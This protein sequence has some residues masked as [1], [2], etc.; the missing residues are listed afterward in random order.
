MIRQIAKLIRIL[1]SE[2]N[3]IQI[4]LAICFGLIVGFTQFTSVHNLII[5]FIVLFIRVNLSAFILGALTFKSFSLLLTG[6]FHK[7]GLWLL[8]AESFNGL[9][10]FLYNTTFWKFDRFNNTIVA[11]GIVVSVI[12]FLPMLFFFN[13]LITKYRSYILDYIQNTKIAKAIRSTD[14]YHFYKKYTSLK[15]AL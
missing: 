9:A 11:G 13:F 10:T 5:L 1:N 12:G 14:F 6:V 7:I 15:D 4:S 3:P 2:T 8:T